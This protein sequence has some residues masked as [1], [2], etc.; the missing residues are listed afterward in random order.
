LC[1]RVDHAVDLRVI[2]HQEPGAV[3]VWER[4]IQMW[5]NPVVE[6]LDRWIERWITAQLM[7]YQ[8]AA[9][10]DEVTMDNEVADAVID[11]TG[12]NGCSVP[13]YAA[14][15]DHGSRSHERWID[16]P[17]EK[18]FEVWGRGQRAGI[19]IDKENFAKTLLWQHFGDEKCEHPD[20]RATY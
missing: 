15:T 2:P 12:R 7:C 20:N 4:Q 3:L 17:N 16:V 5:R 18:G 10:N 14:S 11:R 9:T 19:R 6:F 1:A 8:V 13:C